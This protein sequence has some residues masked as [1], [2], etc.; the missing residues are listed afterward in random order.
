MTV[1]SGECG[2]VF[3]GIPVTAVSGFSTKGKHLMCGLFGLRCPS[4]RLQ[5]MVEMLYYT[6]TTVKSLI[7]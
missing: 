4:P 5:T 7:L 1:L 6:C 2:E 3:N